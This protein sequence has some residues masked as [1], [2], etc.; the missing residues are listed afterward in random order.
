MMLDCNGNQSQSTNGRFLFLNTKQG[1]STI[2]TVVFYIPL[3]SQ[4]RT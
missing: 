3:L 2:A 1:V 4:S